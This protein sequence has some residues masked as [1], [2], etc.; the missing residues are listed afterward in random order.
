MMRPKLSNLLNNA[1]QS[2]KDQV[3]LIFDESNCVSLTNCLCALTTNT[4]S[5]ITMQLTGT[6]KGS[7]GVFTSFIHEV[8]LLM[9]QSR[10]NYSHS[11]NP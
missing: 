5:E 9:Q 11:I 2:K 7:A 6:S 3:S 8:H 4:L 1:G 10:F